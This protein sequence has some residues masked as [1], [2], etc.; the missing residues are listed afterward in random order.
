MKDNYDDNFLESLSFC[1]FVSCVFPAPTAMFF[2][3]Q[4]F[5]VG[6]LVFTRVI[7]NATALGTFHFDDVFR[8]F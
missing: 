7:A 6:F 8:E 4:F 5:L 3:L 2:Q 1:F